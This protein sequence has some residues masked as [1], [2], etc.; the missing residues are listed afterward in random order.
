MVLLLAMMSMQR[1]HQGDDRS[2][3]GKAVAGAVASEKAFY[4][5]ASAWPA[6]LPDDVKELQEELAALAKLLVVMENR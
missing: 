3:E 2:I 4:D 1:T 5:E 6:R